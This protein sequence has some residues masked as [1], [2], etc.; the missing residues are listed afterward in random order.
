MRA[1]SKGKYS[2][3][4]G[5]GGLGLVLMLFL[6]ACTGIPQGV[7]PVTP[8]D[9]QRYKGEWYE[10]MRLDHR[11]ERNLSN[12]TARY[13]VRDDGTVGVINRGYDRK[14]C[15]WKDIE[16]R[17]K[18]LQKPDVASLSV[19]FFGPFAGGY[20]VFALDQKH[21]DWAAVS[22][23]TRD[24]LWI[25][26]RKPNLPKT[27]REQLVQKARDLGFPVNELILVDQGQPR[28]EA[29]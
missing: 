29:S 27:T 11:F 12:V 2:R 8:F 25:L 1:Q 7:E 18:F 3:M 24:Y 4:A 16:G 6:S 28:C 14:E 10:V 20:H 19:S 17:A 23:P 26:A 9:I 13:T 15:R 21:Y 22:G 5:R